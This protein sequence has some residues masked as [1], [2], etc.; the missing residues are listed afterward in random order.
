MKTIAMLLSIGTVATAYAQ[1][2]RPDLP[3]VQY[4]EFMAPRC[5]T[6]T[7]I[8]NLEVRLSSRTR[9]PENAAQVRAEKAKAE[10]CR[11]NGGDYTRAEWERMRAV[12][13]GDK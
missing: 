9:E 4:K 11:R 5:P 6:D 2:D 7:D 8:R 1:I 3:P 10:A 12:T 13:N